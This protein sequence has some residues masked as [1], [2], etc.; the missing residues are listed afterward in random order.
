LQNPF[1][2]EKEKQVLTRK[3]ATLLQQNKIEALVRLSHS[4][5]ITDG[6]K[7]FIQ[8]YGF[9]PIIPNTLVFGGIHENGVEF[10]NV[11]STAYQKHYNIVILNDRRLA[12]LVNRPSSLQLKGDIHIWWDNQY[13]HNDD[14][15]LV[16]AYMLKRSP[17][18]SN[19]KICLNGI[20]PNELKRQT[21]IAEYRDLG[22]KRRMPLHV[23]IFVVPHPEEEFYPLVSEIS[24]QA[25]ILFIGFRPPQTQ[26]PMESYAEY[27]HSTFQAADRL[28]PTA[29]V[30]GSEHTP[31][32][33]ILK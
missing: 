31:L 32:E 12:D 17:E 16:L 18:W 10:A 1:Q 13:Q 22:L 3:M 6:M 4:E 29:L 2:N 14:F 30:L 5:T 25:A 33:H 7:Q 8:H 11:V 15:M 9:G 19:A 20:A 21:M 27:L 23:E 24:K 28:P 26:E